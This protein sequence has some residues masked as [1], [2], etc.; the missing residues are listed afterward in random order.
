MMRTFPVSKVLII[1]SWYPSA[2]SPMNSVFIPEQA[3]ALARRFEVA[4][5][6]PRFPSLGD[7]LRLRWGSA[8]MRENHEGIDTWRVRK[9]K[10]PTLRRWIPGNLFPDH[11]MVF[12]RKFAAAIRCGFGHYVQRC[13]L[14]DI[15]HAHVVLPGGWIAVELAEQFGIPIVLTEHSEPFSMHLT[16]PRQEALVREVLTRVNRISA[17]SPTLRKTIHAFC[18]GVP[19][20]VIGNLIE[21]DFFVPAER[22]AV[23]G[24]PFRFFFLGFLT[25][26]KGVQHLFQAVQMLLADGFNRFDVVVGGDG[27]YRSFLT[28]HARDLR[29][30]KHIR[31]LGLLDRTNV[32]DQMQACDVFVLPSLGE[33]FGVVLGEAMACGKPVLS[34]LCGGPQDVVT[35]E[36]GILVPPANAPALAH[37]M[38][39][40]LK[41]QFLFHPQVIRASVTERFGA[42]SFLKKIEQ[43]YADTIR[44]HRPRKPAQSA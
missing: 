16:S 29:I 23:L 35:P 11:A 33:T 19:I 15:I 31:F 12:Y 18:P 37:A 20:D 42:A 32:R 9:L 38:A 34:T 22:H 7:T 24:A 28:K 4:V 2:D 1:P 10:I 30:E 43:F 26:R 40:F 21:T 13:G 39:G 25:K 44:D 8:L 41:R 17:V 14:P 27:P 6:T 3:R 5:L 36:T